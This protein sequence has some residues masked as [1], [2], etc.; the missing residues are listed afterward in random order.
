[1]ESV[2]M[3]RSGILRTRKDEE[4]RPGSVHCG[5]SK[6]ESGTFRYPAEPSLL[7]MIAATAKSTTAAIGCET[8]GD[9]ALAK[10]EL[11]RGLFSS[12]VCEP[13]TRTCSIPEG[14]NFPAL[15]VLCA[16]LLAGMAKKSFAEQDLPAATSFDAPH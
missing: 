14:A 3:P 16:A 8:R 10:D 13:S 12:S 4:S 7:G 6:C 11:Q 1:M 2:A 5:P 15:R 9:R